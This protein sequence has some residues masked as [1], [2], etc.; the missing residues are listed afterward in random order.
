MLF[1]S[2]V[3]IDP[4]TGYIRAM[5]GGLDYKRDQFNVIMQGKRQPGSAFKPI[6]YTAAIDT[7]KCTLDSQYVDDPN[8]PGR[9]NEGWRPKNYNNKYSHRRMTVLSA[10]KQSIN[11]V[12]VK[13]GMETGMDVVASYAKR[14]G[15][16][17]HIEPVAPVALEIGRAHV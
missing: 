12:A 9:T 3:C 11:T 5:V 15:I 2:L 7:E 14:M 10:L 1:R 17:S 13:V 16:S 4:R 8:L 6:V